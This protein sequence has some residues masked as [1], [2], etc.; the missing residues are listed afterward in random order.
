MRYRLIAVGRL[1]RGFFEQGCDRYVKLLS[2]LT[3]LEV[4]EVRDHS[5]AGV[6]E[7]RERH[8][9]ESLAAAD[10]H[11]VLVDEAG[12]SHTTVGLAAT[13]S[14]LE[15]RG[16]SRMTFLVGGPDGHSDELRAAANMSLS[17]SPFTFPHE[18]ARLVL[19]EQLYRIEA[20]RSGHPYHRG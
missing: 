17:L 2:A 19:L 12:S 8:A 20:L 14:E 6:A 16:V 10:G 18:L 4:V 7:A 13:V 1:K 11:L 15:Q 3:Q 9:R 5:S